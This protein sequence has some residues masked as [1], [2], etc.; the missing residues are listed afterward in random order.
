MENWRIKILSYSQWYKAKCLKLFHEQ[1]IKT[2]KKNKHADVAFMTPRDVDMRHRWCLAFLSLRCA[3]TS[4]KM[5]VSGRKVIGRPKSPK[6]SNK[7]QYRTT[8]GMR[9]QIQVTLAD[10]SINGYV[11]YRW[12]RSVVLAQIRAE[13]DV[14]LGFCSRCVCII[15]LLLIRAVN[16]CR[17]GGS[18]VHRPAGNWRVLSECWGGFEAKVQLELPWK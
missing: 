10:V 16:H 9:R 3:W 1:P 5:L 8:G 18:Q 6:I 7:T 15:L 4:R 13:S 11:G 17:G 14:T 2:E 12:A